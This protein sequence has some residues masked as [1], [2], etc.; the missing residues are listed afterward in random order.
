VQGRPP[1]VWLQLFLL[2]HR[3]DG[4][5]WR[6]VEWPDGRPLLAQSW[7]QVLAL[8]ALADELARMAA[9]RRRRE[10]ARMRGHAARP[11]AAP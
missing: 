6:R 2:T 5:G 1:R 4:E 3:P 9:E 7:P 10:A 11:S 8:E